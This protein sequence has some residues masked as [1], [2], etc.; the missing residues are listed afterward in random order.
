MLMIVA[1][2]AQYEIPRSTINYYNY[3]SRHVEVDLITDESHK[4]CQMTLKLKLKKK[5]K[6]YHSSSFSTNG[7]EYKLLERGVKENWS[8]YCTKS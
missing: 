4:K 6:M 3:R 1:V 2:L 5:K 7:W 8:L